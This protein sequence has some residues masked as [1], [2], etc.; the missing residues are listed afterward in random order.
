[1]TVLQPPLRIAI[2]TLGR[3]HVL[4]L[5]REL[6]ALGHNVRF[7]SCVPKRRAVNFGLPAG[8]H[9]ALFPFLAPLIALQR[10]CRGTRFALAL[11]LAI[12]WAADWLVVRRLRPCDVF[13]G[14]SGIYVNAPASARAKF[15]AKII[16]ERGS[17]HIDVQKEILDQIKRLNPGAAT[18][19]AYAARRELADY[20]LA[21][22]IA[23]PSR[24]VE[25]SF[26]E[27]GVAS[28]KLF[29]NPYGVDL[30]MFT[31]DRAVTR[32]PYLILFVGVWSYQKG[33][34][35]L[36]G[37][38]PHL[39]IDGFRLQHV[40]AIGDVPLPD[41]SWF[42]SAGSV[43]QHE[44]PSWYRRAR[45]LVL[46][47]RQ[48]GLSLVQAQALACD[49]P[50]IGTTMTGAVDLNEVMP[51]T[52]LVTVV[53]VGDA[54]ALA[55]AIAHSHEAPEIAKESFETLRTRLSWKA[56]AQRYEELAKRLVAQGDRDIDPSLTKVIS[57]EHGPPPA[58]DA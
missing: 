49:C 22:R 28:G 21:D 58:G 23:I 30:A 20:A 2:A 16:I 10:L 39:A 54:G 55:A 32:D 27:R 40:G 12:Y 11:D 29:R 50:V 43:D 1:M 17:V 46:P 47:S 52:G 25:A 14:M 19:P 42:G 44:L 8:C 38:M 9:V 35:V 33:V 26:I 18:V 41:A 34:D 56:Y 48:E 6:T 45:C 7:Y 36:V 5:A 13:I 57:I 24:H 37:A 51:N 53:P 15:G 3:F 31:P 4:D